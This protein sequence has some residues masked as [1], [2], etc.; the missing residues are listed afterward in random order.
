[1]AKLRFLKVGFGIK[2]SPNKAKYMVS[3]YVSDKGLTGEDTFI[4]SK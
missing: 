3:D 1:M 2:V 4:A